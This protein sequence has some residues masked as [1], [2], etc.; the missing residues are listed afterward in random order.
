MVGNVLGCNLFIA[1]VGGPIIAFIRP[2]PAGD[3]GVV[4][5]VLMAGLCAASWA[6]MAR[7]SLVRRSEAILLLVVYAGAL[8]FVAR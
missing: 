7:G 8:P 5:L 4:S 3:V 6:F 2:G 1:L